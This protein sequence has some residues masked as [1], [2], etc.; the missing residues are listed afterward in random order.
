MNATATGFAKCTKFNS[1]VKKK[2]IFSPVEDRGLSENKQ[3]LMKFRL[4]SKRGK[5][6]E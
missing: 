6:I 5:K 4:W 3:S 2:N 1:L